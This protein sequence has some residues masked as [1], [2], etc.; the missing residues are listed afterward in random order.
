MSICSFKVL[1]ISLLILGWQVR[2]AVAQELKLRGFVKDFETNE[3]VAGANIL[4]LNSTNGTT[5][6]SLGRFQ[7]LLIKDQKSIECSYIGYHDLLVLNIPNHS[8]AFDLDNLRMVKDYSLH[9]IV[10][11]A[12]DIEPDFDRHSQ[13]SKQVEAEYTIEVNGKVFR[14]RTLGKQI[15]FDLNGK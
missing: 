4:E 9:L 6:D 15:I 14:P 2:I 1:I 13:L 11:M 5:V 10:E 12:P 7:L 3:A 8:G